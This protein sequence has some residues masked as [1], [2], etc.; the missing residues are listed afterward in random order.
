MG[1][2]ARIYYIIRGNKKYL[3]ELFDYYDGL[4]NKATKRDVTL[5]LER[6]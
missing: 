2:E 3:E 1:E 4:F 6:I 5:K